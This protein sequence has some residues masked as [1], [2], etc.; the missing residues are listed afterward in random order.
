MDRWAQDPAMHI[1]HYASYEPTAIKR[2][3]GRHNTCVDEVDELL[4]AGVFVDLYRAVR[5]ALRASV[6]SYSIKSLEPLYAFARAV[7]L[8]QA[9]QALQ[10]YEAAFALGDPRELRDFLNTIE[11]YNRDDCL[12]ALR[13]RD[14]LEARR[15]DLEKQ[16][17]QKLRRPEVKSGKP[18]IELAAQIDEAAELKARLIYPLPANEN[19]WTDEHRARWLVAQLLEWHRR[20]EKSAWWEYY[21]LCELSDD[22]LLEDN[23]ALGGLV[24]VGEVARIKKSVVY[25]YQFPPQDHSIDRALDVRDPRTKKGVGVILAIDERERTID[26]KRSAQAQVPHPTALVPFNFI[27]S[28][29]LS[30]SILHLGQH[31]AD[32]GFHGDAPFRAATDLLLRSRPLALEDPLQSLVGEDGKLTEAAIRLVRTLAEQPSV[33]PIQ[34]PPGTG[35]TYTGAR[36]ILELVKQGRRVGI[37]AVS[38]KVISN[39]LRE[40]CSSADENDIRV[41]AIQKANEEDACQ[42]TMVAQA[43]DNRAVLDGLTSGRANVAGGTIWLWAR[44]EMANSVDVL[45]VDEAGQMSLANVLAIA[46]A[47]TS[48]VL[49]GD[50]QQLEQPQR[51]VHPAGADASA[52]GHLLNGRATIGT[53][54]GV[55]LMET[56]RLHQDICAFTSTLFYDGRLNARPEN[57]TQRLNAKEALNGTGFRLVPVNHLGNRNESRE[58]AEKIAS[59]V[60]E[61]VTG[62]ATWTD[63]KGKNHALTLDHILIVSPYNAQVSALAERLPVGARIGTVDKFQGQEAPVVFFSMATSS[64]A[65]AP[66]GMEFLYSLNRLN[67]ATSRAQ[68]VAIL[69]A[70]PALFQ[71]QCKTPRQMELA[72]AFCR[73]LEVSKLA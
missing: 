14:W 63:K 68:C 71:L 31:V 42:H 21:R 53:N 22:E 61:L 1:Y 57:R 18:G 41:A 50:P 27:D 17:G 15:E 70:S 37:T 38:H 2:L 73:Y 4:R 28:K 24:Y 20:E 3:A 8:R 62:K 45:F 25:R 33:L 58:E 35:K 46:Q 55:F 66:R 67:V 12:S 60:H 59:M 34:G 30:D 54:D 44:G 47:A 36:M 23:D 29:V 7:P 48:I 65:D 64:P 72:N 40:V 11:G 32:H 9:N 10:S 52:L 39:I 43:K 19:E 16:I 6:E 5:Q 49:L 26:I 51:G 69:V 13:L 56:R